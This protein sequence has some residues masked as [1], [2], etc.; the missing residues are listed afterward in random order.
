MRGE[1][2]RAFHHFGNDFGGARFTQF[3][4]MRVVDGAHYH[5][6]FRPQLAHMAQH[7]HA[8]LQV[9]IG[10]DHRLRARKPC[11]DQHLASTGVAINHVLTG[12]N[13]GAHPLRVHVERDEADV[14]GIEQAREILPAAAI[15]ADNDVMV[16]AK[17]LDRDVVHFFGA[18]GPFAAAQQ[19]AQGVHAMNQERRDQHRQDHGRQHRLHH[20]GCEQLQIGCLR[21]Q[22]KTEF[23]SLRQAQCGTRCER[24]GG[25]KRHRQPADDQCFA[26]HNG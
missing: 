18:P 4:D 24:P 21:Q 13:G 11:C 17:G 5:R 6:Q 23:A 3:V 25:T 14:F 1:H 26:E 16:F 20:I 10:D 19:V 12:G 8:G 9:G 15:A 22:Y 2:Q 7:R